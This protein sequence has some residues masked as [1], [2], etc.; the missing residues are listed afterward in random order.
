[1]HA[2]GDLLANLVEL[3]LFVALGQRLFASPFGEVNQA[4]GQVGLPALP[5]PGSDDGFGNR[6]AKYVFFLRDSGQFFQVLIN[7]KDVSTF[8]EVNIEL[9][10][11]HL[12]PV[13]AHVVRLKELG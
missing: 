6:R 9:D 11:R 13:I 7:R 5:Q 12:I 2:R 3:L 4:A 10:F 8:L 1:M